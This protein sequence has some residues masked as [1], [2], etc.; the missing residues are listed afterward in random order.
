MQQTSLGILR[1]IRDLP[2]E[3]LRPP[4]VIRIQKRNETA[5]CVADAGVTGT[6]RPA[7]RLAEVGNPR[8][9]RLQ[10]GPQLGLILRAVIDDDDF[11]IRKRLREEGLQC[12]ANQRRGIEHGNDD[13]DIARDRQLDGPLHPSFIGLAV[14]MRNPKRFRWRLP[15]GRFV[16][17]AE[18]S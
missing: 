4:L 11:E 3:L 17:C 13:A 8:R 1:E 12:P 18:R 16:S 9:P 7:V 10:C 14:T 6:G 5:G 2:R 15:P